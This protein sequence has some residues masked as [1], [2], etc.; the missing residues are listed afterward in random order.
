M[1]TLICTQLFYLL[2]MSVHPF[3]SRVS[4]I[5]GGVT[6]IP[7]VTHLL[8]SSIKARSDRAI[9]GVQVISHPFLAALS[10]SITAGP[11]WNIQVP[12]ALNSLAYLHVLSSIFTY[13][14]RQVTDTFSCETHFPYFHRVKMD[15]HQWKVS[16]LRSPPDHHYDAKSLL[17]HPWYCIVSPS[18]PTSYTWKYKITDLSHWWIPGFNQYFARH[19]RYTQRLMEWC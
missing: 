7:E 19:V 14:H 3:L 4:V 12:E 9:L 1:Q 15:L 6:W 8:H 17:Q 16:S 13:L 5:Y 2:R 11:V 18:S 10:L